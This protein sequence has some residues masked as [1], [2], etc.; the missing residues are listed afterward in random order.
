M[1]RR[2][3][4]LVAAG[5]LLIAL[6]CVAALRPVPYVTMQP[7]PVQDTLAEVDGREIVAIGDAK[8]YPTKGQLDLT[9]VSVTSPDADL[10][11]GEA[12]GA[13]LDPDQAVLPREVIYPPSQS[14]E[15]AQQ[16]SSVEMTTSQHE[17]AA[18]ALSELGYDISFDVTVVEVLEDAPAQGHLR[19]GDVILEVGGEAVSEASEV[20][21]L[22]Q[23]VEPGEQATLTVRRDGKRTT[24]TTPTGTAPDD[25]GRTI[26]G[27][28]IAEEPDLPFDVDIEL[29]NQ[30]GGP[31][32]GLMFSLAIIDKLTPGALTGG[33][34]IAGTGEI[35]VDGEVDPIGGIQ[36]KIAGANE[37][38][39][40]VFLVP[41]QNCD[42]A[43]RADDAD[44]I[45]LVRVS[46]LDQARTA[47][48][49]LA[50]DPDAGP[51]DG[52]LACTA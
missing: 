51:E 34:H 32:A 21:E 39:A 37:A 12:I 36:Q 24:V 4:T 44:E 20:A 42:E 40:D 7:G 50:D 43:V 30:I 35:D 22:L 25:A 3:L 13:W 45:N 18:A 17:A 19:A 1:T 38:G 33:L 52:V 26:V 5:L 2:T 11:I 6:V 9:T 14:V 31:S 48:E 49:A 28:Q 47:V 29:G 41:A 27:I 10:S 46:N 16:Q 23:A 8:V 15:E